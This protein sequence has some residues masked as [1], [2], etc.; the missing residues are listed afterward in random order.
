MNLIYGII[1]FIIFSLVLFF[2]YEKITSSRGWRIRNTINAFKKEKELELNRIDKFRQDANNLISDENKLLKIIEKIHKGE[3]VEIPL[4]A[5]DYIYRKINSISIVDKNGKIKIL[6]AKSFE[7][8]QKTAINLLHVSEPEIFEQ[9][10]NKSTEET[11]TSNKLYEI[12]RFPDGSMKK[13][14]L[15]NG[16]F[17][18]VTPNGKKYH[19]SFNNFEMTVEPSE[20]EK[21]ELENKKKKKEHKQTENNSV[22]KTDSVPEHKIEKDLKDLKQKQ[23]LELNEIKQDIRSVAKFLKEERKK[24]VPSAINIS[25]HSKETLTVSDEES[26]H[27]LDV[28]KDFTSN[29]IN[30]ET[31]SAESVKIDISNSNNL[32]KNDNEDINSLQ[33]DISNSIKHNLNDNRD[34]VCSP[35]D[36]QTIVLNNEISNHEKDDTNSE[37]KIKIVETKEI[38]LDDKSIVVVEEKKIQPQFT[39]FE[40]L[41]NI[42]HSYTPDKKNDESKSEVQK[43]PNSNNEINKLISQVKSVTIF[44]KEAQTSFL[45]K[46]DFNV[47]LD[48]EDEILGYGKEFDFLIHLLNIA[49]YKYLNNYIYVPDKD[50]LFI[51][52][53]M[54]IFKI[55]CNLSDSTRDLFLEKCKPSGRNNSHIDVDYIY[56][57]IQRLNKSFGINYGIKPFYIND[58]KKFFYLEKY[59]AYIENENIPTAYF[60]SDFLKL[61]LNNS[62]GER[63]K[64]NGYISK[65][66]SNFVYEETVISDK[67]FN[68]LSF[69]K[70]VKGK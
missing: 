2:V 23:A 13:K 56:P 54:F 55:Y 44:D 7:E 69:E 59:L 49:D 30:E 50:T 26:S 16:D 57:F 39:E 21:E 41:D 10:E 3:E 34:V 8:F 17:L 36:V 27:L 15:Q 22:Q 1:V 14:N 18:V 24:E 66:D 33:V 53:E 9:I 64:E 28:K 60:K 67:Y 70:I 38:L 25:A 37:T 29:E 51:S 46:I 4:A 62:I 48:I 5:F 20:E 31:P 68:L 19:N 61:N 47:A 45:H 40:E 63:L 43:K 6:N 35:N 12:T 52:L 58:E 65:F 11:T 42:F 32:S